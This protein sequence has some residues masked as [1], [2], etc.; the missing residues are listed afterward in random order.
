[1]PTHDLGF[2]QMTRN[3]QRSHNPSSHFLMGH[4]GF[5]SGSQATQKVPVVLKY[6]SLFLSIVRKSAKENRSHMLNTQLTS[7]TDSRSG[8]FSLWIDDME[9]EC[10]L[11]T[12]FFFLNILP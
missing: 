3:Y 1:M 5:A 9:V 8:T 11:S 6:I 7:L 2:S 12:F 10:Y 4:Q